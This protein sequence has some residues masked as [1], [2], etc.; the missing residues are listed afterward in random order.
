MIQVNVGT[1]ARSA[2]GRRN[3]E[4]EREGFEE[5]TVLDQEVAKFSK[6]EEEP[7]RELTVG[8]ELVLMTHLV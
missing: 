1:D 2:I 5:V 7:W 6:G 3:E 8:K 4:K